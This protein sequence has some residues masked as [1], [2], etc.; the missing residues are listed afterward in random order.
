MAPSTGVSARPTTSAQ[1]QAQLLG[2]SKGTWD[3]LIGRGASRGVGLSPPRVELSALSDV[4][5]RRPGTIGDGRSRAPFQ[6]GQRQRMRTLSQ[7][8]DDLL[9]NAGSNVL[10]QLNARDSILGEVIEDLAMTSP[11]RADVL[12][13]LRAFY[14]K[15]TIEALPRIK[16]TKQVDAALNEKKR[17]LEQ[18]MREHAGL[19]A[20]AEKGPGKGTSPSKHHSRRFSDVL[21]AVFQPATKTEKVCCGQNEGTCPSVPLMPAVVSWSA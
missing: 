7:R 4:R 16:R 1:L 9:Q 2:P 21:G 13:R 6:N 17:L 12:R 14:Y 5:R 10:R 11:D 19:T 18:A 8:Y 20:S 3:P 15:R